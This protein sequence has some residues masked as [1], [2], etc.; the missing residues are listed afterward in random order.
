[1]PG[2]PFPFVS[3]PAEM[4]NRLLIT[5]IALLATLV[6]SLG[7]FW[8]PETPT[9]PAPLANLPQGGNFTLQAADG[10]VS[11]ADYRGRLGLIYFGYTYCP[12]ICP[13]TLSALTAGMALLTPDERAKLVL[14]FISVDPARDT[15]AHLKTY[16][17]FFDPGIIGVTGSPAE[18][19]EVAGRYGVFY[20]AQA[21]QTPGGAYVVDH[22][23]D[24]FIVGPDGRPLARL[25]HGMAPEHIAA[26]IRQ[27]LNSSRGVHP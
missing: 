14:F 23:S 21:A 17:E 27:Y 26:L 19:A 12:D 7:V 20:S 11:L 9:G 16:V 1:M 22:S 4:S 13:T 3:R 15:P 25:S 5:C 18:L 6:I 10:P 24:S 8:H 2:L